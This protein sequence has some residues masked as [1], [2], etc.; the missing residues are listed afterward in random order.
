MAEVG[1]YKAMVGVMKDIGP[2]GKN[3]RNDAQKYMFRGIDDLYN[4]IQPAMVNNGVLHIPTVME[5]EHYEERRVNNY[6]KESVFTHAIVRVRHTFYAEDGSSVEAVT[7]GEAMDTSDKAFNKAQ[8]ASYKYALFHIFNIPTEE[9]KK[10]DADADSPGDPGMGDTQ[11]TRRNSGNGRTGSRRSKT[12]SNPSQDSEPQ[13][14]PQSAP[15]EPVP[16]DMG[17]PI[18]ASQAELNTIA[19]LCAA[20]SERKKSAFRES[21]MYK[22]YGCQKETCPKET[23]IKILSW[24]KRNYPELEV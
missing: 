22:K 1:I 12:Q 7:T 23:A 6:N 8:T 3:Q 24:F 10:N 19:K 14:E 11:S 4:A 20:T 21:D 9:E 16:Q 2:I 5:S 13:R 15:P 18:L 17:N